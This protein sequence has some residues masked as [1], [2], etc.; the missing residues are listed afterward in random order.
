MCFFPIELRKEPGQD[1]KISSSTVSDRTKVCSGSILFQDNFS[2]QNLDESKWT[3]EQYIPDAP[4]SNLYKVNANCRQT[5]S[6]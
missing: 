2:R 1:C 4:V 5:L 6:F 3:W